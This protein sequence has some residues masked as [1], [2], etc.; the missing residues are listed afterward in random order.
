[1]TKKNWRRFARSAFGQPRA[2]LHETFLV[3]FK[4]CLIRLIRYFLLSLELNDDCDVDPSLR[5]LLPMASCQ[6]VRPSHL[7]CPFWKPTADLRVMHGFCRSTSTFTSE[8]G[9]WKS[10]KKV[11]VEFSQNKSKLLWAHASLS[12][13]FLE[14]TLIWAHLFECTLL[15]AHASLTAS[16]SERTLNWTLNRTLNRTLLWAHAFLSARFFKRTLLSKNGATFA[17]NST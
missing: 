11:S 1:M 5:L 9:V 8:H 15:W 16:F 17:R 7:Q 12:A 13:R 2:A 4:Y 3:I 14:R 6:N 10:S